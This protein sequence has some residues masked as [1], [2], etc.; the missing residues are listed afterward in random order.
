N[1]T[2]QVETVTATI[3]GG[4]LIIH[5]Q[6]GIGVDLTGNV[7]IRV[8]LEYTGTSNRRPIF[9]VESY[10]DKDKKP[11][12]IAK[13]S[14]SSKLLIAPPPATAIP[15]TVTMSYTLR[16]VTAGEKTLEEGDDTIC[17]EHTDAAS[18]DV[19][20]VPSREASPWNFCLYDSSPHGM[21]GSLQIQ[22]PG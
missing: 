13:L 22:R 15:A 3:E 7:V 11:L 21:T 8:D 6:G 12:P 2:S 18:T 19:E 17:N 5:R 10:S 16:H 14:V 9:S 1:A 20:L 4:S